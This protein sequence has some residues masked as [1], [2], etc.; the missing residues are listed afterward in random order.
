MS[1]REFAP[2]NLSDLM[3]GLLP[4]DPP[5]GKGG[6]QAHVTRCAEC[7]RQMD[8]FQRLVTSVVQMPA[9]N[10]SS[11]SVARMAA[12][13]QSRREEVLERRHHRRI[14]TGLAVYAWLLFLVSLPLFSTLG[15]LV[16]KRL[17]LSPLPAGLIAMA[18]GGTICWM[19][20]FGM[21]PLLQSHKKNQKERWL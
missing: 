7:A 5:R 14:V 4:H 10:L 15:S 16:G 6:T 1:E 8:E 21:I 9:A 18:L 17:G 19:V 2:Q 3:A 20:G 13:A 11:S 12:L